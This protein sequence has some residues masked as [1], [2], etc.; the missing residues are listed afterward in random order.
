MKAL[1]PD[2][3]RLALTIPSEAQGA[4]WKKNA[5]DSVLKSTGC[6][7]H[8]I[9]EYGSAIWDTAEGSP[10]KKADVAAIVS[11]YCLGQSSRTT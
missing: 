6:F 11:H 2:A 4:E 9:Q 5:I 7:S 3:T 10:I 1:S 8:F